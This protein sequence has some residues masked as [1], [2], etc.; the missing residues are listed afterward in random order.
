MDNN[1]DESEKIQI[2]ESLYFT[3]INHNHDDD[4]DDLLKELQELGVVSSTEHHEDNI[5]QDHSSKIIDERENDLL[6]RL[7]TLSMNMNQF[8]KTIVIHDS[9]T[10]RDQKEDNVIGVVFIEYHNDLSYV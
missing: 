9:K 3:N 6:E 4:D 8:D 10:K 5:H 1:D 2:D 7:K